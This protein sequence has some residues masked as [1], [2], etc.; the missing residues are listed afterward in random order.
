MIRKG[1]RLGSCKISPEISG[2]FFP[3]TIQLLL[4]A[5]QIEGQG[6]LHRTDDIWV[7]T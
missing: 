6:K 4:F 2:L 1:E 3:L 5:G 7:E